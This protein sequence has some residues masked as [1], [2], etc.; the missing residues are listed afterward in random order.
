M[1]VTKQT[2]FKKNG[3]LTATIVGPMASRVPL[4]N[5]WLWKIAEFQNEEF[6]CP[7]HSP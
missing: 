7:F 4:Y 6:P 1:N 2:G 5:S 3:M